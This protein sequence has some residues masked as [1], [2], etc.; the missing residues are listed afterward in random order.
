MGQWSVGRVRVRARATGPGPQGL[1]ARVG[2][3]VRV[4]LRFGELMLV[5]LPRFHRTPSISTGPVGASGGSACGSA[6]AAF[7]STLCVS[8]FLS[9]LESDVSRHS[10]IWLYRG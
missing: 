5:P 8:S 4:G 9:T 1:W 6:S 2:V 7:C 3:R 10:R